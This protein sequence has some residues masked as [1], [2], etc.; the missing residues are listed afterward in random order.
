MHAK[1]PHDRLFRGVFSQPEHAA[2]QLRSILPADVARR[3]DW[4]ALRQ[5]PESSI[6]PSSR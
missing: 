4:S 1:S 2:G 5:L 6:G 3:I